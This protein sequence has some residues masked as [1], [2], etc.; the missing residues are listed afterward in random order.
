MRDIR[1][2]VRWLAMHPGFSIIVVGVLGLS[3]GFSTALFSVVN[4]VLLRPLPYPHPEQLVMIWEKNSRPNGNDRNTVMPSNAYAW[5]ERA[6]TLSGLAAVAAY[7]RATI[8]GAGMEAEEVPTQD[9]TAN[10][11]AVLGAT[12]E[13]GR[14]FALDEGEGKAAPVA[15]ISDELWRRRFMADRQIIGRTIDVNGHAVSVVGVMPPGFQ[16]LNVRA[17]LWV[18]MVLS[19]DLHGRYLWVIGRLRAGTPI[20]AARREF[21]ALAS[22]L[23]SEQPQYNAQWGTTVVSLHEQVVGDV[24]TTLLVTFAAVLLLLGIAYFNVGNLLLNRAVARRKEIGLRL[25]LGATPGRLTRQFLTE[26]ACVAAGGCLVGIVVAVVLLAGVLRWLPPSVGLPRLAEISI[27]VRVIGFVLLTSLIA[28]LLLG[29]VPVWA[30]TSGNIQTTLGGTDRGGTGGLRHRQLRSVLV[31]AEVALALVLLVG[32][33]LLVRTMQRLDG[34]DLGIRPEDVL[35]FRV[36]LP[37]S[38]YGS[39]VQQREFYSALLARLQAIPGIRA[40]GGV[41][42]LPLTGESTASSFWVA[43]APKPQAGD[44]PSGDIR[45]IAGEYFQSVRIP[46]RR[47]RLF[48]SLDTDNSPDVVVVNQALADRLWP[49]HDPI[50]RE[51]VVPWGKFV[52]GK[53][54]DVTLVFRVIGVVGNDRE[55]SPARPPAPAM[56]WWYQ[57]HTEGEMSFVMR[58]AEPLG[59]VAPAVRAAAR[60]LDAGLAV[61]GLRTMTSVVSA[62][63]V[64]PRATLEVLGLFAVVALLLAALGLYGVVAYWVSNRVREIGVRVA[65]GAQRSDVLRIVVW[66]ALAPTLAGVVAGLVL[67]IGATRVMASLLYGV[68]PTDPATLVTLA[69]ILCLVAVVAGAIPGFRAARLNPAAA[70]QAE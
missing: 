53:D 32:A 62:T 36:S 41:R 4:G 48:G 25:A 27:D 55:E 65:L 59:V 6:R 7:D 10:L 40:A 37:P 29:V 20:D 22:Q 54:M 56:Y 57:Q 23:A 14:S 67:A 66:Q 12:P 30:F 63:L 51:I 69:V 9:V 45:I 8:S 39:D 52:N 44:M 46:L 26:S 2:A 28:T 15:I 18:P 70:L 19:P 33:G 42:F 58:T 21:A 64:R 49:G 24:R 31:A 1:Q 61:A 3:V 47:G 35:A 68:S 50:G 60:G 17:D 43:D 5:R 11:F 38:R 13:V 34:V 16:L